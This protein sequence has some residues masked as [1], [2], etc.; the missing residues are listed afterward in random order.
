MELS[1]NKKMLQLWKNF[2]LNIM[3]AGFAR[4]GPEW[5]AENVCSPFSRLYFILKGE[6]LAHRKEQTLRLREGCIYL[7]PA[8]LNFCYSCTDYMEQLFFHVNVNGRNG[9]DFFRGCSRI[10]EKESQEK[11]GREAL[12]LYQSEQ[13]ADA[14]RLEG[15]IWEE[16]AGFAEAGGLCGTAAMQHCSGLINSFFFLAQRPDEAS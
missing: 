14:F 16:L 15:L 4:T 6:G 3:Y 10:L 2:E 11:R 5:Q 8:G 1:E 9:M 12:K 7:I 13:A